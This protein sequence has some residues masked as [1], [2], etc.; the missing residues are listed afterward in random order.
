MKLLESFFS[1]KPTVGDE[2]SGGLDY[3]VTYEGIIL[4]DN[5]K[6]KDFPHYV[7]EGRTY[8]SWD[9]PNDTSKEAE[10]LIIQANRIKLKKK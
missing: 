6:D 2:V 10:R 9:D 4:E 8:I 1:K 3:G 7:V 5:S